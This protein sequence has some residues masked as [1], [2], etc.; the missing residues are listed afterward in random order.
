[1]AKVLKYGKTAKWLH[2]LVAFIVIVMLI[3]GPGLEDMPL[4]ERQQM[5]MVH[6]GL[7]T[8]V[9]LFM[10]FRWR[11]RLTHDVPGPTPAM[12][13]W[14]TRLSR[15]VHWSFYVLLLLQPIFGIMQAMFITEYKVLAFGVINYSG[16][17]ADDARLAQIF[18]IAHGFNA[19]IITL[20]VIVHF[21]A[22]LYHH[23]WRKD[24]VLRRML[25]F[26]KVSES[27]ESG[28]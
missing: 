11:W 1:M 10:L 22:A 5:I 23:F 8:L 9:L 6:S 13:L 3:F 24:D 18:H 7:G 12:G 19:T 21:T 16:L 28:P 26:G 20:L 17:A 25:P 15:G 14:Q 4:D 2:W 27:Q